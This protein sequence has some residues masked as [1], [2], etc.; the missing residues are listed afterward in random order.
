MIGGWEKGRVTHSFCKKEKYILLCRTRLDSIHTLYPWI[1]TSNNT[2]KTNIWWYYYHSDGS[3][4]TIHYSFHPAYN[5]DSD[6]ISSSSS[7]SSSSR[8]VASLL[9]MYQ[10]IHTN[11][12]S[13][14][15]RTI[16]SITQMYIYAWNNS[17]VNILGGTDEQ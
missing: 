15:Y 9:S 10:V 1:G 14:Y 16:K 6:T 8:M 17:L 2:I 11:I 7:S 12:T 5:T 4:W 3:H 13:L